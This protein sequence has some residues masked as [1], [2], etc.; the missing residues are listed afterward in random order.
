MSLATKEDVQNL[1][2]SSF[3]SRRKIELLAPFVI[4]LLEKEIQMEQSIVEIESKMEALLQR[5]DNIHK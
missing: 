4:H 3:S 2:S 1:V 5:L